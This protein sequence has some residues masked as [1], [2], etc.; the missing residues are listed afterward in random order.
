MPQQPVKQILVADDDPDLRDILRSVLEP[1]GFSVTEA[2][3]GAAALDA[4]RRRPPDLLILDYMMPQVT[5]PEVCRQL[6]QDT[7]LRHVPIIMLTGKSELQDKVDGIDAGADDYLIKPFE[8]AELLARVRMV[9]RR[10]ITD[11]EANP[12]TRLP[13]NVSIQRELERRIASGGAYA[14]CYLDLDRFKAFNDHYGFKRGDEVIQRTAEI[15]LKAVKAQGAPG[16]FVGHIGG[17]DFI[18]V[19]TRDRVDALCEAVIQAFDAMVPQ[20]YDAE[21]RARGHLLH[22]DRKGQQVKVPPLSISIAVVTNE[23]GK[24]THPGQIAKIGAELKAYAKQ[25]D[26]SLYVKERRTGA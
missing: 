24:V 10:T 25:F 12:L 14:V 6:K 19:T 5:G 15:L 20:L 9:L 26:R 16:D 22:T 3:D 7:L 1:A 23:G 2:E 18:A 21:D 4:I 8:P 13:G 11:L 17:D